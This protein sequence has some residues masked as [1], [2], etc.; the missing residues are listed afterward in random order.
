MEQSRSVESPSA[1]PIAG[2]VWRVPQVRIEAVLCASDATIVDLRSPAE[3]AQDRLPGARN[4]PLFDDA[5]RALVGT[6]Y[7]RRSPEEAF[8]EGRRIVLERIVP[9][10]ARILEL[11]GR[12]EP[13]AELRERVRAVT[14]G[15]Q[16]SFERVLRRESVGALPPASIVLHCW[17]GGLRSASVTALLG[18][19]GVEK[20]HAIEGGYKSYRKH[21]MVEL[22]AWSSPPAFVLRGL[23]GVGKTLVL[24]EVERLRPRWTIDLEQ[25][26]AHRSSVLGMI[27]L[28]P[29]SQRHFESRLAA[30]LRAGRAGPVVLE[31]ESRKVGDV[32]VPASVWNALA[33]GENLLLVAALERRIDVLV[34]DYLAEPAGSGELRERLPFLEARLGAS[35]W[36]GV[37]VELLDRGAVRELA[38]ILLERYYDPLYLH[39]EGGRRYSIEID[40]TDPA[41]AAR[42]VVDFVERRLDA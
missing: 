10:V 19:L 2:A 32:I 20:V 24:R 25:L 33:G 36:A 35:K 41:R 39:S 21:V 27:G 16:A 40:A 13:P 17:R 7:A 3:H 38:A 30:R 34:A 15:G 6:I 22:D 26:A 42:E 37:L 1:A 4:L 11:A 23:T 31:G 8:A 12:G 5:E 9:L 29:V 18:A 28:E 14:E